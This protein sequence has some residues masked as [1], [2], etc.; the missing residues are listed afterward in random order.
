[1]VDSYPKQ[2]VNRSILTLMLVG[3]VP[4]TASGSSR[5]RFITIAVRPSPLTVETTTPPV[6]HVLT[7]STRH[8]VY[9]QL[10]T[11]APYDYN[12]ATSDRMYIDSFRHGSAVSATQRA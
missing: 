7:D 1:M 6:S 3:F 11:L 9:I 10:R 8:R 12:S 5:S 4:R 2:D